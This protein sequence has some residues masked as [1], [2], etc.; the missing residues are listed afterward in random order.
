MMMYKIEKKD[1]NVNVDFKKLKAINDK[2]II[3]NEVCKGLV[4]VEKIKAVECVQV[5]KCF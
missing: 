3:H 5:E 4:L 2:Y 1:I